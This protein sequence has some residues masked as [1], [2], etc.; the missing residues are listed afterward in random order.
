[1]HNLLFWVEIESERG[2]PEELLHLL[3]EQRME[4]FCG[5]EEETETLEKII[6]CQGTI[7]LDSKR[8]FDGGSIKFK[9]DFQNVTYHFTLD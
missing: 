1:M 4:V 8:I 7:E 2:C 6:M 9:L 3:R 5:Q